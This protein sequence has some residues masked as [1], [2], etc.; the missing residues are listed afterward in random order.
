MTS[1][2]MWSSGRAPA[3]STGPTTLW[4]LFFVVFSGCLLTEATPHLTYHRPAQR[5]KNW[6]AFIVNKNVSCTVMDGTES[7]IQPQYRCSW[8]QIHCQPILAY[9]VGFRPRYVTSYK[10]VT[11]LEWRCCPGFKGEDCKDGPTDKAKQTPIHTP[12]PSGGKKDQEPNGQQQK[13]LDSKRDF[14]ELNEAQEKKIQTLEEEMLRLTQ[15]VIDLQTSLS[16]VNENLKITV[17]E[18]ASKFLNT[19]LNNLTPTASATGGKTEYYLPGFTG[20]SEK[21]EGLKDV[22]SELTSAREELQ[23][24]TDQIEELT[25]KINL[26]EERLIDIEEMSR[27]PTATAPVSNIDDKLEALRNEMLEGMD[28]KMADLKNSCEYKLVNVQQQCEDNEN[29]CAEVKDFVLEKETELRD[30]INKLRSQIQTTPNGGSSCC[31]NDIDSILKNLGQKVDRIAEANVVLNARLDNEVQRLSTLTPDQSWNEKLIDLEFKVNVSERNVEEHCFYIEDTLRGLINSSVDSMSN[32]IDW[33]LQLLENRLGDATGDHDPA[34]SSNSIA[35]SV[36]NEINDLKDVVQKLDSELKNAI[37]GKGGSLSGNNGYNN[38]YDVLVQTQLDNA[39][40]L[41]SLTD[42]MNEKFE[43]LQNK[44]SDLE[45][46]KLELGT[47]KFDLYRIED[48][49]DLLNEKFGSLKD[50]V[51]DINSTVRDRELGLTAKVDVV[52]KLYDTTSDAS[53]NGNCCKNL[54]DNFEVLKREVTADKGKCPENSQGIKTA[55]S[56]V[57]AR[58]SKLENVCGK[59]DTIS[60]S[61]QRIKDGLNK[62]VTSLWNC[63][64]RINGTIKSHSNDIYGL[65]NSVQVFQT[66][67]TKITTNLQDLTKSKPGE[68]SEPKHTIEVKVV[69]QLPPKTTEKP[70]YPQVPQ[71]PI[72]PQI[73]I[74]PSIPKQPTQPDQPQYPS[75][76]KLP[77]QPGQSQLPLDPASTKPKQPPAKPE[78]PTSSGSI[79]IPL[80]PGRNGV[81]LEHGQAGP[82]GRM[83]QVGSGRPQGA[84]GEQDMQMSKGFAGAPGYPKPET[85]TKD[86]ISITFSESKGASATFAQISFSAGL[87]ERQSSLD[88]GFIPFNHVLVNDGEH[89]NP[90]TGIFTAPIEGRYMLSA[91]L[92]PEHNHYVEAVLLVSNVSVAQLDSSGYRRELL[93]YHRPSSSRPVCSGI[94]TFNLILNLKAGDEV[95]IVLTGGKLANSDSDE[96]YSTFSGALLYPS[97]PLR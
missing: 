69:P 78:P 13:P 49:I 44:T 28:R 12:R 75:V 91:V 66:E 47:V 25:R 5:G 53:T 62:H 39:L 38:N 50:Q 97:T 83:V 80:V 36:F 46:L 45:G 74:V 92:T 27:K 3:A 72:L 55:L 20:S 21:E 77:S 56:N 52:H 88:V 63:I 54:Q 57:D 26:Y 8:N 40:L 24:K 73:P 58:V 11:E 19:W 18:D 67:I 51:Q 37:N 96:M 61:L 33:K 59:L 22:V 7:F 30:E 10:V 32:L 15:T 70:K 71:E 86:E 65:K 42:N 35:N 95:A 85:E 4:T 84:D 76:P 90:E 34:D 6:C 82:P 23:K 79:V 87:T 41:K 81:I 1:G 89:Y 29:S 94:G 17:Q 60:G 9:K 2:L 16:G 68:G 64:S 43:L 14:Q 48:S 31:T 93:E